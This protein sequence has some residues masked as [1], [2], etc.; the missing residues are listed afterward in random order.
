[1]VIKIWDKLLL[2]V[3]LPMMIFQIHT[4]NI[5][6]AYSFTPAQIDQQ[7]QR[8][9]EYPPSL[10]RLG[11]ILEAKK[12]VQLFDRLLNNFFTVIDFKEY[13]PSRIPYIFSPFLLIGLYVFID[14]REKQKILFFELVGSILLLTLIGPHA[15]YGPFILYPFFTYLIYLGTKR[16]LSLISK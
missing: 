15:K 13:F 5:K 10:A 14:M 11:Y 1:M 6:Q 3:F 2:L 8:M 16:S 4:T 9:N 7:I 12:E